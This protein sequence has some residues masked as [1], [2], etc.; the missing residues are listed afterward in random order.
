MNKIAIIYKYIF[1]SILSTSPRYIHLGIFTL[2]HSTYKH[3]LQNDIGLISHE[4]L[5]LWE[6]LAVSTHHRRQLHK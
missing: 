3:L 6:R 2:I 5:D 4:N 1:Y